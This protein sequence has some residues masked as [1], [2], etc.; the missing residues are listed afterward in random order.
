MYTVY[1]HLKNCTTESRINQKKMRE[2]ESL[3]TNMSASTW[4]EEDDI[5]PDGPSAQDAVRTVK[6]HVRGMTCGRCVNNIQS[7]VYARTSGTK[8]CSAFLLFMYKVESVRIQIL[9]VQ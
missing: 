8:I 1:S 9:I 5:G 2:S 7:Q 4:D 3:K 6:I